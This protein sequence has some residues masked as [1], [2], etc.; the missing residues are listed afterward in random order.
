MK[1]I[2]LLIVLA[3]SFCLLIACGGGS[4]TDT[5]SSSAHTHSFGE[6]TGNKA[7]CTSGSTMTRYCQCGEKEE[8]SIDPLG[9]TEIILSKK[10]PTCTETGLTEGKKCSTCG[11]ILKEQEVIEALGHT[12]EVIKGKEPT[13]LMGGL[14]DGK[15]CT[16]CEKTTATQTVIPAKGHIYSDGYCIGCNQIEPT[17]GIIY[18]V[19]FDRGNCYCTVR[20]VDENYKGGEIPKDI[21]IADEYMGY[22]VTEIWSNA[23][24][25]NSSIESIYIPRSITKIGAAAFQNCTSLKSITISNS[26]TSLGYSAFKGCSELEKVIFEEGC[27]ITEIGEYA[28]SACTSLSAFEVPKSVKILH[29]RAFENCTGL[30]KLE[31]EDGASQVQFRDSIFEGCTSLASVEIPSTIDGYAIHIFYD[32]NIKDVYFMGSIEEWNTVGISSTGSY[33]LEKGANLYFNG[34]LV[35]NLVIPKTIKTLKSDAFRGC[36]SLKTVTFEEGSELYEIGNMVFYSCVNLESITLPRT[37]TKISEL[38]FYNC[39]SLTKIEI[40]ISVETIG[41]E[42]FGECPDLTVHCERT[43]KGY[44]WDY[45][46]YSG[47][48]VWGLNNVLTNE[49]YNYV[50]HNG[51]AYLT[52]YKDNYSL[53]SIP[54]EIDGYRVVYFGRIFAGL[55]MEEVIIPD[56]IKVI[57][58]SAFNNCTGL[59]KINMSRSIMEIRDKAFQNCSGLEEIVIY[60]TVEKIGREAFKGCTKL[61]IKCEKSKMPTSSYNGQMNPDNLPIEW[62]YNN[63]TSNPVYDY[64]VYNNEAYLTNYKSDNVDVII[65]SE[66][67]G[68]KVV[69]F[70]HIFDNNDALKTVIIPNTVKNICYL[71][72]RNCYNIEIMYIPSSVEYVGAGAVS[73]AFGCTVY[74]GA[75]EQP[76]TWHSNWAGDVFKL[77]WDTKEFGTTED[78]LYSWI[79]KNSAP[80]EIAIIGYNGAEAELVIPTTINGKTVTAIASWAFYG[81]TTLTKIVIPNTVKTIDEFA[82]H[83]CSSLKTVIIP[84]SVVNVGKYLFMNCQNVT[85]YCEAEG[86]P[87]TWAWDWNYHNREV[88]WG[89][90]EKN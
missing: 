59:R 71:A 16:V 56:T 31:F 35:E 9:H 79:I 28:F 84:S 54:S 69:Y 72:F 86:Q 1:K 83:T 67:D 41:N 62:G 27:Q 87:N 68:Y 4:N 74:I 52:K 38:A 55:N 3:L 49:F 61:T 88:V 43:D 51:E 2:I 45:N 40:P 19:E 66:I 23:F 26:I 29:K 36:T 5:D 80:D 7:T 89:Y 53:I 39:E 63:V 60:S 11:S 24:V 14:T 22:P 25:N 57:E 20:G 50:I 21:I 58:G 73:S 8:K 15:Y 70:G 64:A 6:W 12:E 17:E 46:W 42:A 78:G 81:N 44:G 33:P 65:P 32:C 77:V 13:C 30:L 90:T 48:P 37:L 10:E 76:S 34:E 75:K 47:T 85:V 82:I 18:Y